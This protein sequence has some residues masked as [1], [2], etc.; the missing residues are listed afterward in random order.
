VGPSIN[1]CTKGLM[2]WSEVLNYDGKDVIV[3]DTEGLGALDE[4]QNHDVKVFSLAVL[5]STTFVYNS[6]GNID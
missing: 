5:L 1:P 3:I 6:V 4:E 2:I